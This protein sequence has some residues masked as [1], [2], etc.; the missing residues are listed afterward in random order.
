MHSDTNLQVVQKYL[1][2]AWSKYGCGQSGPRTLKLT[3]SLEWTDEII[4]FF[5]F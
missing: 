5:A 2:W 1:G 4:W 3:V